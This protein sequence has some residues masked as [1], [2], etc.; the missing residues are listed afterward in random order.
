MKI[1]V[2]FIVIATTIV[3]FAASL[4]GAVIVL[5]VIRLKAPSV[6]NGSENGP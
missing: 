5:V 2:L 1:G 4:V 6:P 3:S